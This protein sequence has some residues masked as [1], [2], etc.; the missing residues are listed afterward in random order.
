M[1]HEP[2]PDG[3]THLELVTG[4]DHVVQIGGHFAVLESLDSDLD[5]L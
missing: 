4:D 3:A 5:V 2:P 1:P